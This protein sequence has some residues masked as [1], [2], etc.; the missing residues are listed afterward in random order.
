MEERMRDWHRCFA[1]AR[2]R[3]ASTCILA[4]LLRQSSV[5]DGLDLYLLCLFGQIL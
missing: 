1:R 5:S 2:Y 3:T 4:S